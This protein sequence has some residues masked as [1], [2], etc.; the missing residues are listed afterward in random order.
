MLPPCRGEWFGQRGGAGATACA[1]QAGGGGVWQ[2]AG[3]PGA[4]G[5][6]AAAGHRQQQPLQAVPRMATLPL[7]S[8]PIKLT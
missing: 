4:G 5:P 3:H 6:T 7:N 8:Q 2:R 1:Q